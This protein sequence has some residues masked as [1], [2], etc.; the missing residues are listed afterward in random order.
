MSSRPFAEIADLLLALAAGRS[1][2]DR[3]TGNALRQLL[4]RLRRSGGPELE[5]T[6][7]RGDRER[8]AES[9]GEAAGGDPA[10]RVL[11][12]S[13][14]GGA[15][16]GDSSSGGRG[17]GQVVIHHGTGNVSP[18]AGRDMVGVHVTGSTFSLS[19]SGDVE[20]AGDPAPAERQEQEQSRHPPYAV[21]VPPPDL[22]LVV[23]EERR[24]GR[25]V[26]HYEL[27]AAGRPVDRTFPSCPLRRDLEQSMQELF[28]GIDNPRG[29]RHR[30]RSLRQDGAHLCAELIPPELAE[31][32]WAFGTADCTKSLLI[33]S[34]EPWIPWELLQLQRRQD[35]KVIEGPFLCQAFDLARWPASRRPQHLELPLTEIGVVAPEDGGLDKVRPEVKFL[36]SQAGP[37]RTVTLL[38]A[39]PQA[40]VDAMARAAFDGWHFAGHGR[41]AQGDAST[42]PLLLEQYQELVPKLL[43]GAAGS[44]GRR[45]PFVFLNGCHTGRGG[46][47]LA[48]PGGWAQQLVRVGAGA[49]LGAFWTVDDGTAQRFAKR[50]YEQ[51]L[52]GVPI[53]SAVRHARESVHTEND[54]TWLAYTLYGHPGAGCGRVVG[55]LGWPRPGSFVRRRNFAS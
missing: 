52:R 27:L 32:L 13:L 38:S 50:F 39:Q 55:G 53:A 31:L 26:L 1:G 10:V 37:Q 54:A 23:R 5:E 51:F 49:F 22:E 33:R 7:A 12:S 3:E 11:L 29:Q 25:T 42:A 24:S 17:A 4:S 6:L 21:G 28:A 47:S 18:L 41:P 8:L 34:E 20:K 2:A 14:T 16:V 46:D 43:S 35:G 44:L 30:D 45:H 40:V 15:A 9:L 36:L 48:R 19:A